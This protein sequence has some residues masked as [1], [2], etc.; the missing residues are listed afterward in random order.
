MVSVK[1]KNLEGHVTHER[2]FSDEASANLWISQQ[3]KLHAFGKH[4]R[5]IHEDDLAFNNEDRSQATSA[6]TIGGPD[7]DKKRFFFP[8]QYS[9]QFSQIEST[10]TLSR[11]ES[12]LHY[13]AKTDW[14]I[15]R[16]METGIEIPKEV[17]IA[18]HAAR[19]MID[20]S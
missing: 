1:V 10:E 6:E 17:Q 4:D 3:E 13:L 16:K 8:S 7:E 9:V 15:V 11:N 20:R 5:W 12:A 19:Q 14:Y 2:T 18:R